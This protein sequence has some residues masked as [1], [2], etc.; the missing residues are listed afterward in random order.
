M[1][2]KYVAKVGKNTI[3][4]LFFRHYGA[5][6]RFKGVLYSAR[7]GFVHDGGLAPEA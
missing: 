3:L 6:R 2:I 7:E 5:A 1:L 4:S